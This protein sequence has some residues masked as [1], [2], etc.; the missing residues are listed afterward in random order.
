MTMYDFMKETVVM[1][2]FMLIIA[3]DVWWLSYLLVKQVKW[4]RNKIRK[5]NPVPEEKPKAETE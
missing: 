5:E 2:A 3:A 4:V 1:C